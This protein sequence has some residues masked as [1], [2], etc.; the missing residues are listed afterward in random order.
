LGICGEGIELVMSLNFE[1]LV[2]VVQLARTNTVVQ[3]ISTDVL[4]GLD[5]ITQNL[6]HYGFGLKLFQGSAKLQF[7]REE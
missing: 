5:F 1:E 6:V 3:M 2:V 7:R 4:L